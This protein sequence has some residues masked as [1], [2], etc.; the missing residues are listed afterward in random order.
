MMEE[1]RVKIPPGKICIHEGRCPQ[2][3][4][5]M[6]SDK[7]LSGKPAI[8]VAARIKGTSG[9]IHFNPFYGI[10]E[11]ETDLQ[12]GEGDVLDMHCPNCNTSLTVEELCSWCR[13]FMFAIHLPDGGEV[14]AC[15]V[16]G[17]RN[18]HLTLVKLD[19][20]L[21]EFYDEERK[22]KM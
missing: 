11:Y 9:H 21:D 22:P 12:L 8:T 10:F 18:H 14:R 19:T 2:G 4:S 17:C 16:V 1:I 7:L 13:A 3:C 15:P 5:L 20:L 6:N